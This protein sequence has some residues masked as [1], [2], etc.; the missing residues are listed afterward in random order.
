M[1]NLLAFTIGTVSGVYIAQKY[2]IP[3]IETVLHNILKKLSDLEK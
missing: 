1:S 2:K 3:K